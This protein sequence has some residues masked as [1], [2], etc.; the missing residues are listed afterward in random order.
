MTKRKNNKT[1]GR[2]YRIKDYYVK[3]KQALE[4]NN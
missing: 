1:K 4:M 2:F 3:R